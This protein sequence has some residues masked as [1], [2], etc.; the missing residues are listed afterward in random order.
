MLL[1]TGNVFDDFRTL[2]R[3]NTEC[4]VALLQGEFPSLFPFPMNP[5]RGIGFDCLD[6]LR[7]R[8]RSLRL[9]LAEPSLSPLTGLRLFSRCYPALVRPQGGTDS[10]G[11]KIVPAL[12]ASALPRL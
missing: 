2:Y 12:R 9:S 6:Q 11:A 4:P 3:P 5:T 8:N 10:D 1:L 7:N